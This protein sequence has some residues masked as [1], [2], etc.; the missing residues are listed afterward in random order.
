MRDRST[1]S[2]GAMAQRWVDEI[3]FIKYRDPLMKRIAERTSALTKLVQLLSEG[4]KDNGDISYLK[5]Q[6]IEMSSRA[7]IYEKEVV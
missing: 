2:L 7:D 5:K 1:P 3:D 4:V 6:N